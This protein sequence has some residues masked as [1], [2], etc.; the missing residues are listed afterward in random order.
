M[1]L[2]SL[3]QMV[4]THDIKGR[5]GLIIVVILVLALTTWQFY[6]SSNMYSSFANNAMKNANKMVLLEDHE[7]NTSCQELLD[8]L[9]STFN[10]R[11]DA[12][13]KISRLPSALNFDHERGRYDLF[14]PEANC[15]TEERFGSVKRFQAV[16]DGPKFVCGV[17]MIKELKKGDCLVYSLGSNNK[18][19]YEIAIRAHMGCE[20]HT[21]DP[22]LDEPF[23]GDDYATFHPWAIGNGGMITIRGKTHETMPLGS[24]I[25]KLGHENRTI[26]M[27]KIDIETSEWGMM[28]AF[29][30]EMVSGNFKVDQIQIELHGGNLN[31]IRDFFESAD[32]AKMRV[33]HK[34]RNHWGCDGYK[35]LEY[36]LVGED[37]LRRHHQWLLC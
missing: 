35:C 9:D 33:M 27:L 23:I 3:R 20:V 31:M 8:E 2:I 6:F 4:T 13:Q 30:E 36:S 17:D 14:E 16:G 19:D 21:F 34:E 32:R 7:G 25:Q 28:P 5:T 1:L 22:T 10:A 29:F 37:F 24:V 26:D 18:I 12:R 15:L 11:R